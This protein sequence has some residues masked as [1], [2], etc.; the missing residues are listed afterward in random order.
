MFDVSL[1]DV[2]EQQ[3]PSLENFYIITSGTAHITSVSGGRLRG[4]FSGTAESFFGGDVGE[5]TIT[6]GAFDVPLLS[7]F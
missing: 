1:G 7:D 4:T 3:T 2:F 6:N 5:I